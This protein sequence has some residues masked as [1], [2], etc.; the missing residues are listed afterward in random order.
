MKCNRLMLTAL[1]VGTCLGQ[2]YKEY[3]AN[4]VT[5]VNVDQF[6]G[7]W[8]HSEVTVTHGVLVERVILKS[9]DPEKPGPPG[10]VLEFHKKLS[11]AS[12]DGG[13]RTPAARHP[14]QEILYVEK[15]TGELHSGDF[16]WKVWEGVA[17]LIPPNVEHSLVNTGEDRLELA[18]VTAVYDAGVKLRHDILVRDRRDLPFAEAMSVWNYDV[19]CLFGPPDGLHPNEDVLLV[20]MEPMT[21]SFPHSHSPHWEEVWLKLPPESSYAFLGSE[22][23][24][25]EPNEAF[26]APPDGKTWHSVVNLTDKPMR[27]L[28]IGHDTEPVDYPAEV[29]QVPSVKPAR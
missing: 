14:E 18:L 11:V 10:A 13:M 26:L 8:R 24:L 27:W 15:G 21:N 2:E 7:S 16:K 3:P 19:Q 5:G 17:A 1:F 23:R 29:Y 20:T 9:G 12:L 22:V 4:R 6:M 25:Q 28:Y